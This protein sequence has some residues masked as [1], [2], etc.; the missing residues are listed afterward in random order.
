M[1]KGI[2]IRV[3]IHTDGKPELYR[4][5]SGRTL[6]RNQLIGTDF[7]WRRTI[8]SV[9]PGRV[10]ILPE[11]DSEG[12]G[13][14][15]VLPLETYLATVISSEMSAD[16]PMEFLKTH[17]VLS[18]SWVLGKILRCHPEGGSGLDDTSSIHIGWDDTSAHVGYHVCSDD[19]C[20]RY[21]GESEIPERALKAISS[22]SGE[23]ILDR[24]GR[25]VDARFSK[26]CGGHTE[27]FSSC[28]QDIEP[29]CIESVTDEWCDLSPLPSEQREELL[30]AILKEYDR[31]TT[32]F[33]TWDERV[34]KTLVARRLKE[35]FG[36]NIG[37][38][39]RVLQPLATGS[40]GRHY[41]LRIK[42]DVGEA[43]IGKE[44]HIRRILSDTHL[45]SSAF[46]IEDCGDYF[47]LRGRGWGHGVGLCQIGAA[48]MSLHHSYT[49]IIR[50]YFPGSSIGVY[51][52]D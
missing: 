13:L 37:R 32:D 20:Q 52:G 47:L 2:E 24:E 3:G 21:Q 23:V 44:L 51:Q 26:C 6:L 27:L 19:H 10:E 29:P 18:R 36:I 9:L 41:K 38:E 12:V 40:G 16:S 48:H 35:C 31:M 4:L 30:K 50:K 43:I 39:A 45:K 15:N 25:P 5:D 49:D 42:G 28:W 1:K 46:S 7:H 22:T 11:P 17:A 33:L 14:V 34:D 8:E